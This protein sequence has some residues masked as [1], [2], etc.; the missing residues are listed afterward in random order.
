MV[1][2]C[3]AVD[4]QVE[5]EEDKDFFGDDERITSLGEYYATLEPNDD[6][7]LKNQ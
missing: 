1:R 3:F 7:R 6:I 2:V 4:D 5:E